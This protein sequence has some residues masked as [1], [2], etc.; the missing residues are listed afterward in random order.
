MIIVLSLFL[1]FVGVLVEKSR[2]PAWEFH[3]ILTEIDAF[4]GMLWYFDRLNFFL[5]ILLMKFR[6]NITKF[7]Q[8]SWT[9]VNWAFLASLHG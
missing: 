2:R 4:D 3:N 6:Q 5:K 9:M 7:R 8:K 1:A